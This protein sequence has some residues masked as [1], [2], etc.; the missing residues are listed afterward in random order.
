MRAL[1]VFHDHGEGHIL[2]PYLKRGF[3]HVFCAVEDDNG[4]WIRFDAKVGLPEIDVVGGPDINPATFWRD[5]GF[6]VLETE[7][8]KAVPRLPFINCNCVGMIKII[9]GIR[10]PSVL[11]PWQLYK[12]MIRR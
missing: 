5:H 4:Y 7:R 6:T 9:L 12:Y 2:G 10:A 8:G 1:V 3:R 11:T